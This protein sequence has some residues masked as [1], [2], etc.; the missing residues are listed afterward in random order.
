MSDAKQVAA[1]AARICDAVI[2]PAH[3]R[4]RRKALGFAMQC[5]ELI[6]GKLPRFVGAESAKR[7]AI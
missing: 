2:G 6:M 7:A 3:R 5:I 1:K 4:Q